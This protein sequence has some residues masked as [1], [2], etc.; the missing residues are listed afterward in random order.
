VQLLRLRP[1]FAGVQ[2]TYVSVRR[3]Y[4]EDVEGERFVC[5]NDATRW[6]KLALVMLAFRVA[7]TVIRVRPHVVI[8]TGAAPGYFAIRAA[9]LVGAKTIWIDSI[10]NVEEVSMACR[11]VHR[12]ADDVLTQWRHL[13]GSLDGTSPR[14]LGAVL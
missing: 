4:A 10:A 2:V 3:E 6:N 5:I 1:A 13:E 9:R 12:Y 7:L 11:I 8:S 14:Y